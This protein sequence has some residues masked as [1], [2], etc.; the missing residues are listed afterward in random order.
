MSHSL[1]PHEGE[2]AFCDYGMKFSQVNMRMTTL[3]M[4]RSGFPLSV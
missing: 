1:V 4:M 2:Y 3:R